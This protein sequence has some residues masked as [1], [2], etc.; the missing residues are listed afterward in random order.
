MKERTRESF[1]LPAGRHAP[2][3]DHYR[4]LALIALTSQWWLL[5]PYDPQGVL[6]SPSRPAFAGCALAGQAPGLIGGRVRPPCAIF[7]DLPWIL[8]AATRDQRRSVR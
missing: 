4:L 1:F 6:I 5:S 3:A 7:Y 2:G 8:M